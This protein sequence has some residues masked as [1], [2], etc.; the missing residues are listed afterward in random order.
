[1]LF[2]REECPMMSRG[3][4]ENEIFTRGSAAGS[5]FMLDRGR[6]IGLLV[7]MVFLMVMT[8]MC[9]EFS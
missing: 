6:F 9:E 5:A 2:G 7:C 3:D 1:M 8:G 4:D